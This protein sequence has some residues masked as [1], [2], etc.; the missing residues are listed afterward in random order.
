MV[1]GRI[2]QALAQE[3]ARSAQFLVSGAAIGAAWLWRGN[4]RRVLR[5]TALT[6]VWSRRS[7]Y[8]GASCLRCGP[9]SRSQL[10]RFLGPELRVLATVFHYPTTSTQEQSQL[11]SADEELELQLADVAMPVAAVAC[12]HAATSLSARYKSGLKS[13]V[14]KV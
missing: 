9:H 5:Q 11:H 4:R 13:I 2:H 10:G 8:R 7:K 1:L 3:F 12:A 14:P 6:V